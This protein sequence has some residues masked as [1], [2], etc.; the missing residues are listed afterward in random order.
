MFIVAALED[1]ET[2]K[3][4]FV[5]SP[6]NPSISPKTATRGACEG[7]DLLNLGSGRRSKRNLVS[8]PQR[9][10]DGREL[11]VDAARRR[12]IPAVAVLA[13]PAIAGHAFKNK[14]LIEYDFKI[15]SAEF[16]P[17][18]FFVLGKYL[19]SLPVNTIGTTND[20]RKNL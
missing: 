5:R 6:L 1:L 13:A 16:L 2:P 9:N 11:K 18:L 20:R 14:S 3:L 17:K 15:S 8:L 12:K 10:W 19:L 7:C 4:I